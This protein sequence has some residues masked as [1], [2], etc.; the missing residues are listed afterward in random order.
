MVQQVLDQR[1]CCHLCDCQL[2][3]CIGDTG[4]EGRLV[5]VFSRVEY[6]VANVML[7]VVRHCRIEPDSLR[8]TQLEYREEDK[9]SGG[10][11]VSLQN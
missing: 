10:V 7:C 6:P 2:P 11:C 5:C 9:F 8:Q 4:E 3:S 1:P